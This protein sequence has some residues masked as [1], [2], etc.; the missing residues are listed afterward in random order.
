M[1]VPKLE[2]GGANWVIYKDR[3]LWSINARGLLEHVDGSTD[4][5]SCPVIPKLV[6]RTPEST[7]EV[8]IR[9]PQTKEEEKKLEEWTK[10][11]KLWKQGEAIVKQQIAATIPDSL[12]MKIRGKTT[13]LEIWNALSREFQNK[14]KMV[15]VDLRRRLQQER[16]Q[17][18]GDVRSHFAKLRTMREDLAAMG[19]PPGEDEF[20]AIILSSLPSSYKPYISALN[21]T[22]SV[23]GTVLSSDELMQTVTDEYERRSIG[24]GTK[25]GENVA[26]YTNEGGGRKGKPKRKGNCNN[27]NKPGHWARDCWEEGGGKEGQGPKRKGK[28]KEKDDERKGDGSKNKKEAAASVKVKAEDD[29]AW[30]A[31]STLLNFEDEDEL[32]VSIA[33]PCPDLDD[34]LNASTYAENSPKVQQELKL[35]D[36]EDKPVKDIGGE[37]QTTTFAAAALTE[38][39]PES[40]TVDID[41]FDSGASRH[42]SGHCHRFTTFV[43]IEPKPITAADARIFY[44]KGKGDLCIEVPNGGTTSKFFLKDVLYAPRMGVTLVSISKVTDVGLSVLFHGEVCRIFDSSKVIRAEITKQ[45]GLYRLFT[46]RTHTTGYAGKTGE[47]LSIDELHRRLGHVGHEAARQLIKKGLIKGIELD[48]ESEP[49][50]CPSCEWGKSHWKAIQKER[51][52][53]RATAI[54]DEVHSDVWG[55]APVETINHMKYVATFTD[56]HAREME[57][58]FMRNK[59]ETFKKYQEFEA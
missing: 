19:S 28:A 26:F 36:L 54:G 23:L 6:P 34:L 2:V 38:M 8:E 12:F 51:K 17:E 58:A 46:A 11:L 32:P 42:M 30:F 35:K 49:S 22:S 44:A 25:R 33:T 43:K 48:E 37:A 55:P 21:A 14:S 10:E 3:F 15:S 59:A 20:Y 13:A 47:V 29:A 56:G 5:P 27:C 31:M 18:K 52:D 40:S 7:G 16:C 1:K 53:N 45:D 24:K 39:A 57:I 9:L 50:F 4:E 41:L